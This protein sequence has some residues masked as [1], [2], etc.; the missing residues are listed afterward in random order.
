M[1]LSCLSAIQPVLLLTQLSR[2]KAARVTFVDT[3]EPRR[4]RACL[5]VPF[6]RREATAKRASSK[7]TLVSVTY[8]E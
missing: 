4:R 3:R 1:V 6:G 8:D 5:G 2:Y 7:V